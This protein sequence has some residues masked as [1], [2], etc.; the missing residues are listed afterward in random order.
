MSSDKVTQMSID[1][2]I[3]WAASGAYIISAIFAAAN[4]LPY[5]FITGLIGAV[6]WTLVGMMWHD[7]SIIVLNAFTAAMM[8]TATINF[9]VP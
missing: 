9:Y 5:N 6:L 2:Y 7:R 8:V 3:K 1:W 4:Y